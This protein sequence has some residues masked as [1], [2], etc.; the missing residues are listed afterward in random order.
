MS[1]YEIFVELALT[2]LLLG[3]LY[4]LVALGL[5][6]I[7][8]IVRI[9]NIAH[10]DILMVGSYLGF[11]LFSILGINPLVSSVVALLIFGAAGALTYALLF[12]K[13]VRKP[14]TASVESN[15]LLIAFGLVAIIEGTASLA[16]SANQRSYQFLLQGIDLSG[17]TLVPNR[18]LAFVVAAVVNLVLYAVL[19]WTWLGRSIRCVMDDPVAAR[20]V[21]INTNRVYLYATSLAFSLAGVAGTM[22]GMLYVITPFIG[23]DYTIIAFVVVIIGGAGS[24]EGGWL[25]GIM[26]GLAQTLGVHFTSP[27]VQI[28]IS[29]VLLILVLLIRPRGLFGKR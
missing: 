29:Y 21:G 17:I 23:L 11:F 25:A 5:N 19:R 3:G 14:Q 28:V 7:Y 20:L 13:I 24:I 2:G 6:L 12:S 9:L 1:E 8:G 27:A 22:V 26:I 10:G 16:F 15:S 4:A 18:L